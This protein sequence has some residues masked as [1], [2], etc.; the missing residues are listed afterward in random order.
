MCGSEF[1]MQGVP[2]WSVRVSRSTE[3]GP[4]VLASSGQELGT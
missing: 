3:L 1:E 2:G 4:E